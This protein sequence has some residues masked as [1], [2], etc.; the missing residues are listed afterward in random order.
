MTENPGSRALQTEKTLPFKYPKSS[1]R[2]NK[3]LAKSRTAGCPALVE[4]NV[5]HRELASSIF[6]YQRR[7]NTQRHLKISPHTFLLLYFVSQ[8]M[9]AIS[10]NNI[11]KL[12]P[13]LQLGYGPH[14]EGRSQW[15]VPRTLSN[16]E[17][18]RDDIIKFLQN[19]G[20]VSFL[21]EHRLLGNI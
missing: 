4:E 8:K 10:L 6:L 16:E 13:G 20:S 15:P 3:Q 1:I 19:H 11:T 7:V 2:V 5:F 14:H 9:D 17:P 18:S 12:I 21:A